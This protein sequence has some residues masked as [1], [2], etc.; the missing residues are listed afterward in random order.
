MVRDSYRRDREE[1]EKICEAYKE[2]H[3]RADGIADTNRRVAIFKEVA[4]K[5]RFREEFLLTKIHI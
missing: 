4:A 2:Y 1:K 3:K 5:F